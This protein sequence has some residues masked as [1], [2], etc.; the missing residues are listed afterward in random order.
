MTRA[1]TGLFITI[2]LAFMPLFIFQRIGPFD[3][4]WW[5]S[6]NLFVLLIAAS[7]IDTGYRELLAGDLME[8]KIFKIT[9]GLISAFLLYG[10]FYAGNVLSREL[11]HFAG[12]EIGNVYAFRGDASPARIALLMTLVI[13]PGEELI[14][15]GFVQRHLAGRF[16]DI[17]G[18]VFATLFYTGVHLFTGNIMLVLAALTCG[19]FWGVLY[20]KTGSM[21]VNC[22]SHTAWDLAVFILFPFS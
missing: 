21:L 18:L 11:F 5:M 13:G 1:V 6:A 2:G 8:G 15:R 12:R 14:W 17:R 7:R 10:V 20:M 4:W 3:F 9:V 19:A 16:G 22:I